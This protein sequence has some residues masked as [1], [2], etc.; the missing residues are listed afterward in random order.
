MKCPYCGYLENKVVDSRISR[1][2][3]TIRRRR[4]CMDC[5]KRFTTYE[6]T[7]EHMPMLVKK[8]GRREMYSRSKISKGLRMAFQKREVSMGV[9]E[10]FL[11]SMER[12]LQDSGENEVATSEIGERVIEFL[13]KT[14]AV[15]YVRFASV[16][17]EFKSLEDFDREIKELDNFTKHPELKRPDLKSQGLMK[18]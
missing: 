4:E 15:A 7:E 14:D 13:R 16:Y 17:R 5:G 10:S 18:L 9:I 8:D 2:S 6:K 3:T 11:D 1:E 12:E